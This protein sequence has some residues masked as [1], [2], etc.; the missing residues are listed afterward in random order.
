MPCAT[1]KDFRLSTSCLRLLMRKSRLSSATL[2]TQAMPRCAFHKS[3]SERLLRESKRV[4]TAVRLGPA[5][6]HEIG[7]SPP[8]GM[9]L[10]CV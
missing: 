10:S 4:A 6:P 1:N 9:S 3:P 5:G 7:H 2:L 8:M